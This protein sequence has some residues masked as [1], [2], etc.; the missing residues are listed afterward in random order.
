MKKPSEKFTTL[1]GRDVTENVV[2]GKTMVT[3]SIFKAEKM[4]KEQHSYFYPIYWEI[5]VSKYE[6]PN[7][8][9]VYGIP[10]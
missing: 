5:R 2:A 8:E 6:K 1:K 9:L 7:V 3:S 10:R 4:A